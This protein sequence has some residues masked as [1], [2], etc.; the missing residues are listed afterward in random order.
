MGSSDSIRDVYEKEAMKQLISPR[1]VVSGNSLNT[2]CARS[3]K[4]DV[5]AQV[6]PRTLE[7][8]SI[9]Q[10]MKAS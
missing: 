5:K 8:G 4:A 9:A 1:S 2:S 3:P 10:S 6:I 7:F